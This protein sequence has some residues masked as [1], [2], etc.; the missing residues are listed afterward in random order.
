M[1]REWIQRIIDHDG[2]AEG[3]GGIESWLRLGEA[4]GVSREELVSERHVLPAVRFAVDAYVNFARRALDRGGRVLADGA[5]RPERDPASASPRSRSTTPGSIRPGCEYF[6]ARLVQAPRDAEY[7]L[8]L[9]VER[10]RTREQQERAVAALRVQDRGAL[11]P[12]RGDRAR[13]HA[14]AGRRREPAPARR[15]RPAPVRRRARRAPAAHPRGRGA[16]ERDRGAG[17]RAVRRRALG[18]RHRRGPVGALRRRRRRPTTC[19]SCSTGWRR[20]DWWSMPAPRPYTLVAELSY[21]CPLHC[22]YCSNPVDIGGERYRDELE[23]EHW[24]RVFREAR[25]HRRAAARPH[26]RRADAAQGPRRAR[27]RRRAR[28]G[29]TR[30]SSPRA[31]A[32]RASAPSSSRRRAST[33]SR[34]RSR[35]R[36]PRRTTASAAS[37]P[38]T[39]RSRP[40]ARRASSAS[41]SRST[42][43]CTARTST[44]SRRSSRSPRS[45]ARSG[46]SSR[47]RS[48]TAGRSSTRTR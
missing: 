11:G 46:S 8:R 3:T 19:A 34:S 20:G 45:S 18:R 9:V 43:S 29:C 28:P 41:L 30:R 5:V 35:A 27:R 42:A 26:G 1:R 15:R 32:S 36:T 38:S 2:T 31:R 40:R 12:A 4:L 22:P 13:R 24:I 47:T 7:A 39:R 23:T 25:A 33:T 14:T 37:A 10:C 6:R 44:A 48:T 21:Q 17:A 16:P